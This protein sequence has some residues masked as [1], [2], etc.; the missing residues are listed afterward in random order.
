M[1]TKYLIIDL[2]ATCWDRGQERGR[3]GEIIEIGAVLVDDEFEIV[4]ESQIFVKPKANPTLSDF[5]TGLTTI[6]Q[7]QVDSA[8]GL[9]DALRSF[10][11]DVERKAGRRIGE[12]DFLSWGYYDR[13]Q[14]ERECAIRNIKYPFGPHRSLKHEFADRH[15][16]KPCGMAE[17][18]KMLRIPL[19]GTHHRAIDDAR[20]IAR[21]FQVEWGPKSA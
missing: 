14:F 2:E 17:A 20:N 9:P 15:K 3:Q 8:P 1:E 12:L 11:M 6:T 4:G 18:L 21:I 5:C 16:I 13:K 10:T 19:D 7:A